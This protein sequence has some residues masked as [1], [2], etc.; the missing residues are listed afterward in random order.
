MSCVIDSC[1]GLASRMDFVLAGLAAVDWSA[2]GT[3]TWGVARQ[4][5]T[6]TLAYLAGLPRDCKLATMHAAS[7]CFD[8]N[9]TYHVIPGFAP[10]AA[11]WGWLLLGMITGAMLMLICLMFMGKLRHDPS[12]AHLSAIMTPGPSTRRQQQARADAL[13]YIAVG[14]QPA[15][16]ELATAAR[17]TEADLLS[18]LTVSAPSRATWQ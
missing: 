5:S 1:L 11:S 10:L 6:S 15:L 17:M 8:Q 16:R 3:A 13:R 9:P 18:S 2:L 4:A 12:I 7:I 14:G